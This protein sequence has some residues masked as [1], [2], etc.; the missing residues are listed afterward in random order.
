MSKRGIIVFASIFFGCNS[1]STTTSIFDSS[2]IDTNVHTQIPVPKELDSLKKYCYLI[3]GIESDERWVEAT[4]FFIRKLDKIYLIGAL[5]SFTGWLMDGTKEKDYPDILKVRVVN[6]I[7][8]PIFFDIDISS[9]KNKANKRIEFY[10]EADAYA[11]LMPDSFKYKINSI[12]EFIRYGINCDSIKQ[13]IVCGYPIIEGQSKQEILIKQPNIRFENLDGN[14][15]HWLY[16]KVFNVEDSINY[17][18]HNNEGVP[19][20][21][22]SGSPVFISHQNKIYFG[23]LLS[24]GSTEQIFIV[25]PKYVLDKLR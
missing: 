8:N 15:C 21:G 24:N 1:I 18:L 25:K 3:Y 5:H 17:K 9:I 4:G 20:F 23:G 19:A 6:D 2:V 22:F 13:A 12:N 10:K 14:F 11:Y 7:N 16:W